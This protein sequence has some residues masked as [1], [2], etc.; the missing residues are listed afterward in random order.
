MHR[1]EIPYPLLLPPP[2]RG[3]HL[4][5]RR[6]DPCPPLPF[7]SDPELPPSWIPPSSS[8]PKSLLSL[9][10]LLDHAPGSPLGSS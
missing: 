9:S 3:T 7:S 8:S 6:A 4:I 2:L 10:D 1:M 5:L